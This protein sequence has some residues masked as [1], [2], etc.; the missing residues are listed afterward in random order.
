LSEFDL[1]DVP[2]DTTQMIKFIKGVKGKLLLLGK[3][4]FGKSSLAASLTR[5]CPTVNQT[6][7]HTCVMG[8]LCWEYTSE[9]LFSIMDV[10]G[11]ESYQYLSHMFYANNIHTICA[12]T[13]D[14]SSRDYDGTFVWLIDII[15]HSP[16]CKVFL[17][18][19]K[20]DLF[21]K[22]EISS[23]A[24]MYCVEISRRIDQLL[25]FIKCTIA[26]DN[27]LN[28][29]IINHLESL[30]NEVHS[31]DNIYC[32]SCETGHGLT[33]LKTA[34]VKY[35]I[36]N[37]LVLSV[38]LK[39][40]YQELGNLG[41]PY[42]QKSAFI[43]E[44]SDETLHHTI[45]SMAI[46]DSG[47]NTYTVRTHSQSK[48]QRV[49]NVQTTKLEI[50][51]L[52]YLFFEDAFKKVQKH[53]KGPNT[54]QIFEKYLHQLNEVGAVLWYNYPELCNY[55]FNNIGSLVQVLKTLFVHDLSM[56]SYDALFEQLQKAGISRLEHKRNL[57]MLTNEGMLSKKLLAVFAALFN[58]PLDSLTTLLIHLRI[59]FCNGDEQ[60]LLFP[61][62]L[63]EQPPSNWDET[64]FTSDGPNIFMVIIKIT[65]YLP[66]VFYN[67]FILSFYKFLQ[68][69]KPHKPKHLW[70]NH[71]TCKM[72]GLNVF[73]AQ[74]K[75]DVGD[76][77]TL[78]ISSQID[79]QSVNQVWNLVKNYVQVNEE[80]RQE[81]PGLIDNI[82]QVC[83]VCRNCEH[84][85]KEN[86]KLTCTSIET[87]YCDVT[88]DNSWPTGLIVPLPT[89]EKL[90]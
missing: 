21:D 45:D 36:F 9:M 83:P 37:S 84:D 42:E 64:K 59:A 6:T 5:D 54:K 49:E 75:D 17:V 28:K 61:W 15:T 2:F 35:F 14:I 39:N 81:W 41:V 68:P 73:L 44:Q 87:S 76:V 3:Y 72:D 40:V 77:V 26:R 11:H 79:I 27:N 30:Q 12:L 55:V 53:I 62:Y 47:M 31:V 67:R 4:H 56:L 1:L 63:K 23:R 25:K 43:P 10:G 51:P 86:V 60:Y 85:I 66:S 65:G 19:T 90:Q 18:L 20:C 7:D 33:N 16:L 80:L 8:F 88:D 34:I 82:Y 22:A 29:N 13:H 89:G 57:S 32:V 70:K 24:N 78:Y 48:G 74:S 71:L 50:K 69:N 52:K 46:S 58:F 38:T